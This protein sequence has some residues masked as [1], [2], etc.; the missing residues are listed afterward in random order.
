[1]PS[2]DLS[3]ADWIARI[4]N[5]NTIGDN[6]ISGMVHGIHGGD[7]TRLSARSAFDAMYWKFHAP[8]G[9]AQTPYAMERREYDLMLKMGKDPLVRALAQQKRSSMINFG[10][11]GMSALPNALEAALRDAPNV[12]IKLNS[13][14]RNISQAIDKGTVNV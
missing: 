13:P 4:T 2:E 7:I 3:I 8:G 9:S 6:L 12:T 14:V 5:S 1:M 11:A 10:P